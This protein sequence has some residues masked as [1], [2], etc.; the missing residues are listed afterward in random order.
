LIRT[1]QTLRHLQP[2]QAFYYV[3][4]RGIGA[5][6]VA[7]WSG[8]LR[9]RSG[10]GE[11]ASAPRIAVDQ[12]V[13]D[14]VSFTFLNET[15]GFPS[16]AMQWNPPAAKRLWRYNLHYFDF[17]GDATR[18]VQE[19][20]FLLDDWVAANPQGSEPAWEPY[21]ASLRIV[22]WC[23]FID[24]LP[25]EQVRESWVRSLYDQARWLEK[26]LELHILANHYFE[27]VK[28]ML[29]A[30][31]FFNDGNSARWL[32]AF[33]RELVAQLREQTLTDGG[34]YERSPQYHCVLLD[35]YLDI[36]ELA[37]AHPTLFAAATLDTLEATIRAGV[38]L[39]QAIATPDD[40]YPLFND[41]ASSALKPSTIIQRAQRWNLP[42][43]APAAGIVDLPDTGLYGWKS[44]N[45]YFLIDC[46][47]IGPSYQP[48]HTHCD[49]LS[50]VLMTGGEWLVVDSGVYEYEPGEM[51]RYVR[52]TAAH[53]TVSVDGLEQSQVWGE[54][55]VGRRA[56]RLAASL[57]QRADGIVFDGAYRGFAAGSSGIEHRRRTT[58]T[59]DAAN[60]IRNLRVEDEISARRALTAQSFI[61]LHP[62]LRATVEADRVTLHRGQT[63]AATLHLE[64]VGTM[65][66]ASG[67]YCPQ[68][69]TKQ[70]N[71]VLV[72]NGAGASPLKFGYTLEPARD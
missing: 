21:T 38:A 54:F 31:A 69:G 64:N 12:P 70:P 14:I 18:P 19:K 57:T 10:G 50:Y 35:G 44:A 72:L 55:R 49:F 16:T 27:N 22:N 46:G 25:V 56:R 1:L 67:W 58:L 60:R 62:D 13:A 65:E 5:R 40:D 71:T 9:R 23:R 41:S 6:K 15:L 53:N 51:R 63:V 30:G 42:S 26:N 29:F 66:T 39:L 32:A 28:A 36:F 68:F 7:S 8:E 20:C 47:D 43:A 37:A 4:R 45:E 52:S 17:L 24:A 59:V 2:R 11:Y 48:G 33:Q 61:H 34:H 3:W